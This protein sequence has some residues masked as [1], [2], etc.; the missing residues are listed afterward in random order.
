MQTIASKKVAHHIF[1]RVWKGE[2]DFY[3]ADQI[4]VEKVMDILRDLERATDMLR[5]ETA[6]WDM[7]A[8]CL[9]IWPSTFEHKV[10]KAGYLRAQIDNRSY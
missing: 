10:V 2:G 5:D 6:C 9:S 3:T 4:D 1:N 7:V 8:T